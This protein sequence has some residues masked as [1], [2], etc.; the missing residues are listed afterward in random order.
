MAKPA[1]AGAV[2][3]SPAPAS[4]MTDDKFGLR[5]SLIAHGALLFFVLIKSVFS[6]G[7]PIPYI[8][9]LRVDMVG[10]P[11]VLKKDLSQLSK[12]P[13]PPEIEKALKE[14]EERVKTEEKQAREKTP[15]KAEDEVGLKQRKSAARE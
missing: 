3:R 6:P 9:A 5:V 11:D 4:A 8:P 13:A 12:I 14:A 10:L 1:A 15:A 2:S 7:E